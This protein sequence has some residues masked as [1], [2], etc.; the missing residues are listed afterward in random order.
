M[1]QVLFHQILHDRQRFSNA[2]SCCPLSPSPPQISF[3]LFRSLNV[4]TSWQLEAL[5]SYFLEREIPA[6]RS[7]SEKE[8][9]EYF[10]LILSTELSESAKRETFWSC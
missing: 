5:F 10:T 6:R 7:F 4:V 8:C 9:V 1:S 2:M 3:L